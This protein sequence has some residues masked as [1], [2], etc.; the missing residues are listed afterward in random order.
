MV[1]VVKR[2]SLPLERMRW[3]ERPEDMGVGGFSQEVAMSHSTR[4]SVF[5][6]RA[7]NPGALASFMSA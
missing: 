2:E 3:E 7:E 4:L 1:A 6:L 5:F